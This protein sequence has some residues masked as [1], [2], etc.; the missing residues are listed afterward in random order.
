MQYRAVSK[1][2]KKAYTRYA[3]ATFDIETRLTTFFLMA[4]VA[5][6]RFLQAI[7]GVIISGSFA[8]Q[9]FAR[10]HYEGS[11]LDLYVEHRYGFPLCVWLDSIGFTCTSSTDFKD[12][13]LTGRRRT[14][15][16][17]RGSY[18][19][20]SANMFTVLKFV[21]RN[22]EVQVIVTKINVMEQILYFHSSTWII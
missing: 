20:T 22:K 16:Y 17:S 13:Y 4:E 7:Y 1:H 6:F 15:T 11:D 21:R 2:T 10:K 5:H 12:Q 18:Y 9:F 19:G 14:N 3:K 8:L